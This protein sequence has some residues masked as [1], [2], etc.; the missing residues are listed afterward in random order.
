MKKPSRKN[1]QCQVR[2]VFP[3]FLSHKLHFD[4]EYT[5]VIKFPGHAEAAEA[6]VHSE[7]R[8]TSETKTSGTKKRRAKK[9]SGTLTSEFFLSNSKAI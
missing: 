3:K 4:N 5:F 1:L 8:K 2:N 7:Q 6:A 9:S